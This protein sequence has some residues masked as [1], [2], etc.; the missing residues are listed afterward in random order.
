M[1]TYNG[2]AVPEKLIEEMSRSLARLALATEQLAQV[3]LA[4]RKHHRSLPA[5]SSAKKLERLRGIGITTSQQLCA[6]IMDWR[7]FT[8]R[9][10][11]GAF[12]GLCPTPW[13]SGGERIREQGI[14][15]DG[16][17]RIRSTMVELAWLWS[18]WQP[19]S[20]LAHKWAPELAKKGR[21]RKMAVV[22]LARELLVALWRYVVYDVPIVGAVMKGEKAAVR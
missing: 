13:G 3:E 11:P 4:I 15:K 6:E 22:A 5:E 9:K 8:N 2:D 19:S 18:R 14:G 21:R 10:A 20:E 1:A 7:R 16:N 12:A 17:P